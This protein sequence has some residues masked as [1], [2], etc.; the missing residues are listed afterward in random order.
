V[1]GWVLGCASGL[2]ER[3]EVLPQRRYEEWDG[4]ETRDK[5]S[6]RETRSQ[7]GEGRGQVKTTRETR[8][9]MTNTRVTTA[10][11]EASDGDD[12]ND[13]NGDGTGDKGS[14]TW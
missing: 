5:E 1:K 13:D 8:A 7:D 2:S 12:R 6:R 3:C 9:T 10:R 11:V 14:L 4:V